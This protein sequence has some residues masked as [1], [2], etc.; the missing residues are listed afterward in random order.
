MLNSVLNGA[1]LMGF[2]TLGLF[3]LL[4]WRKTEDALFR[5]FA[6]CFWL[7]A[8]ERMFLVVIDAQDETR[9]YAYVIRLVAFLMI[10]RAIIRKNMEKSREK[11][12]NSEHEEK[13]YHLHSSKY[14]GKST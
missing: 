7:L 3:F 5:G 4:F 1:L 2:S 10:V 11:F 8:I 6:A 12:P 14:K 9:V 13:V